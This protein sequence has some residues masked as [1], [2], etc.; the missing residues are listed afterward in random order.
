VRRR[1]WRWA[2]RACGGRR[3]RPA[4]AHE[5]PAAAAASRPGWSRR[6]P[7]GPFELRFKFEEVLKGGSCGG[8]SEALVAGHPRRARRRGAGFKWKG[9]RTARL[10]VC[11]S[12]LHCYQTAHKHQHIHTVCRI[13]MPSPSA[14]DLKMLQVGRRVA[15][16]CGQHG[17]GARRQRWKIGFHL[18]PRAK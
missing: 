3:P 6:P 5:T 8:R 13:H 17:C 1:R 14:T 4:A 18:R 12:R 7:G 2:S 11:G 9:T 15:R 16:R 10:L